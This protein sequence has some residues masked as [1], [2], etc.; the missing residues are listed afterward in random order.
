MTNANSDL[1]LKPS[2]GMKRYDR[3]GFN[4]QNELQGFW[5]WI[6]LAQVAF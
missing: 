4:A 3:E 6:W 1:Q 5:N 2:N